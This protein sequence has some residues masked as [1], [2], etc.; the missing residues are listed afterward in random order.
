MIRESGVVVEIASAHKARIA[1]D[2]AGGARCAACGI[3][4]FRDSRS[5]LDVRVAR[6]LRVGERVTVEVPHPGPAPSAGLLLLLPLML[7]V[8]G[9]AVG[10]ALRARQTLAAGAWCSVLLGSVPM[11]LAFLGALLYDRHLRS[12]PEH[13][14]RLVEEETRP[15]GGPPGA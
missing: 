7:F 15:P 2:A 5:V 4:R 10:E 12:A 3:C 9:V 1:L 13:Q 14:P 8:L 6:P 11:A